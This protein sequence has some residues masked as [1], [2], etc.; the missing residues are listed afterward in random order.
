[1]K[2]ICNIS[3]ISYYIKKIDRYFPDNK[4]IPE[5]VNQFTLTSLKVNSTIPVL[6]GVTTEV[7]KYQCPSL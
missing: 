7:F 1:M 3:L 2:K 6:D 5:V 4:N